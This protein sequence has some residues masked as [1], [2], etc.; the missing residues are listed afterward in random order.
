MPPPTIVNPFSLIL[1]P[2]APNWM[3]GPVV[4][5]QDTS[6]TS[7]LLSVIVRVLAIVPLMSMA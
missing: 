1:M 6:P 3:Q 7:L 2:S 4:L 5:A